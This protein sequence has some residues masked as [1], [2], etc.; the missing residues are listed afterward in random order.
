MSPYVPTAVVQGDFAYLLSDAGFLSCIRHQSGEV[1]YSERL[2]TGGSRG[3]NFFS[4]PVIIDGRLYCLTTDGKLYVV[5]TG[6]ECKVLS[7]FDFHDTCH[8]T[9]AVHKGRLYVRTNGKL[10]SIGG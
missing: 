9:P 7:D 6:S 5:Q 2:N 10:F 8:A 4:S 1:V 3:A